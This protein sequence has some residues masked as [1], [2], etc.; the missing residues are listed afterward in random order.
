MPAMLT[1]L[2]SVPARSFSGTEANVP[3]GEG[4][5]DS[6]ADDEVEVDDQPGRGRQH[7]YAT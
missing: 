4:E 7:R 2:T 3:H 5:E 6:D 1:M